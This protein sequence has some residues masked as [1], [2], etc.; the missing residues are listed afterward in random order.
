MEL[1][2]TREVCEFLGIQRNALEVALLKKP[3]LPGG[4]I[5]APTFKS[6]IERV[7]LKE[8]VEAYR[9]QYMSEFGLSITEISEKYEVPHWTV[10]Y[11]F[12]R[13]DILPKWKNGSEHKFDE[14]EVEMVAKVVGW[15]QP[16]TDSE[17][18]S[19]IEVEFTSSEKETV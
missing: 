3:E 1:M 14:D 15:I 9:D 17:N 2:K 16:L 7:F 6:G 11:H 10:R 5:F 19:I 18:G 4:K 13:K 12:K 8:D